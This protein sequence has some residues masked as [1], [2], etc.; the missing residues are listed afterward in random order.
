MC[1]SSNIFCEGKLTGFLLLE[2]LMPRITHLA[3][4][5]YSCSSFLNVSSPNGA[6]KW[7]LVYHVY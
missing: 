4:V 1:M 6:F 2:T 3:L 7:S 5:L